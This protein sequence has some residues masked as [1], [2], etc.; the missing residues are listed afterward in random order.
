MQGIAGAA[1]AGKEQPIDTRI[2]RQRHTG[3]PRALQQVE[4][5]GR[6][7]GFK[8]ALNRQFGDF[9]RQLTGLEQHRVTRQQRRHNV[10]V[11]QVTREVVGAKHGDH[12]VGFVPQ[13][14]G[15]VSQRPALFACALAVALDRDGDLVDHAGHFSGRFPQRLAGFLADAVGQ[16][17]STGLQAVSEGFQHRNALV[18]RALRPSRE[19]GAG[20]LHSRLDLGWSGGTALPDHRLGDRVERFKTAAMAVLPDTGDAMGAHQLRSWV[21][22]ARAEIGTART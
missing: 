8:P 4:H 9:R 12:T 7:A 1:G 21:A 20:R 17:I 16:L 10:A 14:G 13:H 6:Q 5:A 2:G 18:Q 15:G 22:A 3:F 11:R 19:R